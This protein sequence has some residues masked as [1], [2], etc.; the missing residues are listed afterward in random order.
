MNGVLAY[1]LGV[2]LSLTLSGYVNTCD[3]TFS[4]VLVQEQ[5]VT[6]SPPTGHLRKQSSDPCNSISRPPTHVALNRNWPCI[7]IEH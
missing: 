3:R 1:S 5:E 2:L 4:G 7:L 6:M